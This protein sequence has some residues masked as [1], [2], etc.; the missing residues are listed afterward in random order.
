MIN[1]ANL[2][3]PHIIPA[4]VERFCVK[5]IRGD[6]VTGARRAVRVILEV[7]DGQDGKVLAIVDGGITGHESFYVTG[8][9]VAKRTVEKPYAWAACMGTK[10]RWDSLNIGETDMKAVMKW[11]KKRLSE[12]ETK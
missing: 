7:R 4:V 9:D 1:F 8:Q 5:G 10:N 3:K 2:I 6:A 12:M 11:V